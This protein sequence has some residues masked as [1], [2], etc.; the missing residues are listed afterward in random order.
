MRY[1]TPETVIFL[2]PKC[3]NWQVE[4]P[5]DMGVFGDHHDDDDAA[6]AAAEHLITDCPGTRRRLSAVNDESEN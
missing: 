4:W 6:Q 2:C 3:S 1:R 5:W